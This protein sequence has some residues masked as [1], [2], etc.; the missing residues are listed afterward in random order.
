M[1]NATKDIFGIH[2]ITAIT[3]MTIPILEIGLKP[4]LQ[5]ESMGELL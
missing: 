5:H 3:A 1:K 4:C 2:N